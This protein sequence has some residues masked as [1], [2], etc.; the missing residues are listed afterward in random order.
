MKRTFLVGLLLLCLG[1]WLGMNLA[2]D[3]PLLSNPIA[4]EEVRKKARQKADELYERSKELLRE[5]ARQE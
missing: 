2:G 1:I 3:R 5:Q 4:Q